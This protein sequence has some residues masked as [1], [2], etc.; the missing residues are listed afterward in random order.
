MNEAGF[1]RRRRSGYEIDCPPPR[2]GVL[3]LRGRRELRCLEPA[4]I[5]M[6]LDRQFVNTRQQGCHLPKPRFRIG[7]RQMNVSQNASHDERGNSCSCA[8]RIG[9]D[10][11]RRRQTAARECRQNRCLAPHRM[12][13]KFVLIGAKVATNDKTAAVTA[14]IAY[15]DAVNRRYGSSSEPTRRDCFSAASNE[16]GR[17]FP[18]FIRADHIA[19]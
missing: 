18:N 13:A 6:G 1:V 16:R 9:I 4:L 14:S 11:T 2:R 8:N 10:Q 17:P 15:S 7:R 5:W 12:R 3:R 19:K